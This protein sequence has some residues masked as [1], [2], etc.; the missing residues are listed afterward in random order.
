MLKN[1]KSTKS[2]KFKKNTWAL[3]ISNDKVQKYKTKG[4]KILKGKKIL[5]RQLLV[6]KSKIE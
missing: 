3:A 6:Q 2:T 1:V 4:T 5:G